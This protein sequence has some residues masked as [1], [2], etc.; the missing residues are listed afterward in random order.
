MPRRFELVRDVDVSGVSGVGHVADGVQ[1]ADGVC[2]TRWRGVVAQTCVWASIGAVEAVHGH[3]GA[4]RI[5][6]VDL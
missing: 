6:W 1:F 4:T 5:V 2:V 3:E